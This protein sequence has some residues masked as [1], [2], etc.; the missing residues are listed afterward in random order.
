[1][2]E[3]IRCL[4]LLTLFGKTNAM[5]IVLNEED[6]VKWKLLMANDCFHIIGEVDL[7][8]LA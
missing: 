5:V 6:T 7:C 8:H 4:T 2:L 3:D 1:M